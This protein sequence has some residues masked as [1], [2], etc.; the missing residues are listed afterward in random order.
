MARPRGRQR[1]AFGTIRQLPSGRFQAAYE[2]PGPTLARLARQQ[3]PSTDPLADEPPKRKTRVTGPHTFAT[4]VQAE[5]WLARERELVDSGNWLPP[6]QRERIDARVA[7]PVS[8]AVRDWI[9][10]ADLAPGSQ[11]RYRSLLRN[12]ITPYR[13]AGVTVRDLT[14]ADVREWHALMVQKNGRNSTSTSGVYT[15]AHTVLQALVKDELLPRNV[16]LVDGGGKQPKPAEKVVPTPQQLAALVERVPSAY[17]VAVQVA[18]WCALRPA[19]WIEVR[20]RD[21]ERHP[22]SPINGVE[23]PDRII[24]RIDRQAHLD[25]GEWTVKLPKGEKTRRVEVPPHIVPLLDEQLRERSQPGKDGLLFLNTRG[26]QISPANFGKSFKNWA[27]EICPG[28]TPHS[29]RH[30][31]GTAYAQ[32]GAT[33]HEVMT[34][35]GHVSPAV[36]LSYQHL[37]Q[38]RQQALA[39]RMSQMAVPPDPPV[40]K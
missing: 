11:T 37:A 36:S 2:P 23:L 5:G 25:N 13:I 24:L 30:F 8:Q 21:V 6:D 16:C 26:D 32:A 15:L 34:A 7:V 35:L 17:K 40:G 28:A 22:Q 18:A 20:R 31:G 39:A 19:E 1:R 38:G 14:P 10:A 4:E 27:K 29:L 9:E 12:H 3:P 33:L